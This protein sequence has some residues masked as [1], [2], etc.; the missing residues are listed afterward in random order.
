MN[1]QTFRG[2]TDNPEKETDDMEWRAA[3]HDQTISTWLFCSFEGSCEVLFIYIYIATAAALAINHNFHN[4]TQ[5]QDDLA[6]RKPK[7]T[8]SR[9]AQNTE[10]SNSS[11]VSLAVRVAEFTDR[12]HKILERQ[13]PG[14]RNIQQNTKHTQPLK[15]IIDHNN[16]SQTM[17]AGKIENPDKAMQ[18]NVNSYSSKDEKHSEKNRE[19]DDEDS[20]ESSPSERV[21]I[22]NPTEIWVTILFQTIDIM[23]KQKKTVLLKVIN[24]NSNHR[25]KQNE[26]GL[27]SRI[28]VFHNQSGDLKCS[29][30]LCGSAKEQSSNSQQS[31][32][33]GKNKQRRQHNS[34]EY[35]PSAENSAE[36]PRAGTYT[37]TKADFGKFLDEDYRSRIEKKQKL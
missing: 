21:R 24:R 27:S 37:E 4:Q 25:T 3:F 23:Y 10:D 20:L 15:S 16:D 13:P 31:I 35:Y 28:S 14:L 8:S 18:R 12:G 5:K 6:T 9:T 22:E 34:E 32:S 7:T 19:T 33:G 30:E 2:F 1:S 11:L 17:L 26:T 29:I 36:I